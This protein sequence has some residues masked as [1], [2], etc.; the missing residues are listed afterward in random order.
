MVKDDKHRTR[1]AH[2]AGQGGDRH[3]RQS[4]CVRPHR[5]DTG[6]DAQ[7]RDRV[8]E[9]SENGEAASALDDIKGVGE[10]RKTELMKHFG[11]IKAI[12][13]ASLEELEKAVPKNAAKAVYEHYT[14]EAGRMRVITG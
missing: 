7:V 3:Q 2:L 9:E 13:T 14:E 12:K 10:K 5:H 4:G 11:T 1:S 6:G 8:P